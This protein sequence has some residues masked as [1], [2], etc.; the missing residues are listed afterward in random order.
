MKVVLPDPVGPAT[1]QVNGSKRFGAYT[2]LEFIRIFIE[3]IQNGGGK[4]KCRPNNKMAAEI[5]NDQQNIQSK[6]QTT[7]NCLRYLKVIYTQNNTSVQYPTMHY[8]F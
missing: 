7:L 3:K 5:Q 1:R 8:D 2:L 6:Q 4:I